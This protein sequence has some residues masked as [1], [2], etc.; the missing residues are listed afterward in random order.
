M[1]FWCLLYRGRD[2]AHQQPSLT[3]LKL[4]RLELAAGA[5]TVKGK[6]T[7]VWATRE[8]MRQAEKQL[9]AQAQASY[10]RT[11]RDRKAA[12]ASKKTQPAASERAGASRDSA[13]RIVKALEGQVARQAREPRTPAL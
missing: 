4:R 13:A 7:G 11:I 8:R 5:P 9:P 2:Y 3:E 6:Q 1:L 12:G 10:E